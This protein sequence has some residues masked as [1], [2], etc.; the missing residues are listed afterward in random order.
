MLL[1]G[2]KGWALPEKAATSKSVFQDRRRLAKLIAAGPVLLAAAPLL[3]ACDDAP[4][5]RETDS[6][7]PLYPV[8]RN[9]RYVI[10]RDLTTEALATNYNN[11]YEFGSSKNIAARAQ[12][13]NLRP[14]VVK[15]DGMVEKPIE[16][17]IDDLLAKM[18]LEE[19]VYRHRCVEAWSMAVPWSG[20]PLKAL[21][22][23]ARPLSKATYLKMTSFY[24]PETAPG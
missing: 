1:R 2:P 16:I 15:I 19:R 4:I 24:D 7:A 11:Y 14:W 21:V 6:S 18:L 5:I 10:D 22:D 20:F 9:P 3:A 12:R 17:G 23:M 13:I 8:E